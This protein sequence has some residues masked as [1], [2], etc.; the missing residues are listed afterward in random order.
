MPSAG[1]RFREAGGGERARDDLRIEQSARIGTCIDR[2]GHRGRM[3][4]TDHGRAAVA[5]FRTR[6]A[7]VFSRVN[8]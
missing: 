8:R 2:D 3:P 5:A 4:L 7:A 6:A 1:K